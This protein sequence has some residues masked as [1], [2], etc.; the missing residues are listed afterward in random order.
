MGISPKL[1]V[2]LGFVA[3]G[4]L[5]GLT[6]RNPNVIVSVAVIVVVALL[7]LG[8]SSAVTSVKAR[9]WHQAKRTARYE[10]GIR[11]DA[12]GVTWTV[13]RR[14]AEYGTR[15]EVLDQLDVESIGRSIDEPDWYMW[16]A[17]F[18]EALGRARNRAVV[19]NATLDTGKG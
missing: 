6:A 8:G 15:S 16:D 4:L 3:L 14:V 19:L 18:A 10:A 12:D 7:A 1:L 5:V 17:K 13:V 9:R 11:K 2:A